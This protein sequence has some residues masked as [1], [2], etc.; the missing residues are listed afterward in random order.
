MSRQK[1]KREEDILSKRVKEIKCPRARK[2]LTK[3]PAQKQC[4]KELVNLINL[5]ISY[6]D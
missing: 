6:S 2:R 1:R 3:Y 5:F 4:V